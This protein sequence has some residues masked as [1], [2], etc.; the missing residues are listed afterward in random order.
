[1]L[2]PFA[3]LLQCFCIVPIKPS[4]NAKKRPNWAAFL[5]LAWRE[6]RSDSPRFPAGKHLKNG[7]KPP[8][9][10]KN[11]F[12]KPHALQILILCDPSQSSCLN[13]AVHQS[14]AVAIVDSLV[15]KIPVLELQEAMEHNWQ[16]TQRVISLL[17]RK[18][19]VFYRQI[20]DL[21]FKQATHRIASQ[22]VN[23]CRQYGK[24]HEKGVRISIHFTQQDIAGI[25]N[26]SRVTV[27]NVFNMFIDQ[28]LLTREGK[29]FIVTD[30]EAL[31][32]LCNN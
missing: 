1:M 11:S 31:Q 24:K 10:G 15:W 29:Y 28:G 13:G 18:K 21:S 9:A 19:D 3:K 14:L 27:G 6:K 20:L 5:I 32:E 16:L 17:C 30:L 22:L 12:L 25:V 8:F 4:I 7:F 2:N 26:A 23:L